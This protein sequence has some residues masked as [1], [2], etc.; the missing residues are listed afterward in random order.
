MKKSRLWCGIL[1]WVMLAAAAT[2]DVVLSGYAGVTCVIL[3]MGLSTMSAYV[4]AGSIFGAIADSARAH[5]TDGASF[6]FLFRCLSAITPSVALAAYAGAGIAKTSPMITVLEAC[7]PGFAGF[8]VPFAFFCNPAM[9]MNGSG[10][11]IFWVSACAV[12]GT[13][14]ISAAFQGWLLWK[15]NIFESVIFIA[16]GLL[17]FIPGTMTDVIGL[18]V[19]LAM[20]FI[21]VK[22][23]K[24]A[25]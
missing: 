5:A 20:I 17:M 12:L 22:K 24:K 7:K 14:T 6:C 23:W 11:E 10:T 16:S 8:M 21:N 3:G 4:I 19:T 2:V 9:M 1:L 13:A 25:K 15:L 18:V